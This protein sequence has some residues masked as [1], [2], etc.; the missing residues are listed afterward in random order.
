MRGLF[1]IHM[2]FFLVDAMILHCGMSLRLPIYILEYLHT[3]LLNRC[4]AAILKLEILRLQSF[5]Y[6]CFSSTLSVHFLW[7]RDARVSILIQI[8]SIH[9]CDFLTYINHFRFA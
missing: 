4:Y 6:T 5:R 2:Y 7:V 9:T 8:V 1:K 3:R